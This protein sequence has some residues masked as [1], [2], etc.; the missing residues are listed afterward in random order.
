MRITKRWIWPCLED[1]PLVLLNCASCIGSASIGPKSSLA[2]FKG[3]TS[4]MELLVFFSHLSGLIQKE[5]Q[6]CSF[7]KVLHHIS[8]TNVDFQGF[9][10]WVN[11][12][13]SRKLW[14]RGWNIV[15]VQSKL[16]RTHTTTWPLLK[17]YCC[18]PN[19]T[20]SRDHPKGER[21]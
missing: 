21:V 12:S 1:A 2:Y 16:H 20:R 8:S 17:K 7:S 19:F 9:P 11:S 14:R 6:L 5:R 3:F 18:R 4:S 10:L 15:F 13:K